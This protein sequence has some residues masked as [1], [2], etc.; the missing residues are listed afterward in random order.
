MAILMP[1]CVVDS[2][3][4][5]AIKGILIDGTLRVKTRIEEKSVHEL[6][7]SELVQ[8]YLCIVIAYLESSRLGAVTKQA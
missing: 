6:E 1:S 4:G 8:D 3:G 2:F 7:M 5:V